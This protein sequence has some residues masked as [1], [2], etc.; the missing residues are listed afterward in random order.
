MQ[1]C[2]GGDDSEDDDSDADATA[3]TTTTTTTTIAAQMEEIQGVEASMGHPTGSWPS[4]KTKLATHLVIAES[5]IVKQEETAGRRLGGHMETTKFVCFAANFADADALA[6]LE[7]ALTALA[8]S[9]DPCVTLGVE[10]T[11]DDACS[12][13]GVQTVTSTIDVNQLA[14]TTTTSTTTTEEAS[15]VDTPTTT[16]TAAASG[17][18][19]AGSTTASGSTTHAGTTASRRL[20]AHSRLTLI[21]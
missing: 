20:A 19:T 11:G 18:T 4:V 21:L 9:A 10:N 12:V 13:T 6:S 1:G 7:T 2:G 15:V 17:S 3:T 16:T 5:N 14:A 8:D